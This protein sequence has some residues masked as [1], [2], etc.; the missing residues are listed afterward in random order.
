MS[1]S[2]KT[3]VNA[4]REEKMKQG[5]KDRFI[6]RQTQIKDRAGL[7]QTRAGTKQRQEV[8]DLVEAALWQFYNKEFN[9]TGGRRPNWYALTTTT[10]QREDE[11]GN[12][13]TSPWPAMPV[14]TMANIAVSVMQDAVKRD[15]T[16]MTTVIHLGRQYH[17]EMFQ[18]L[19]NATSKGREHMKE[20][21]KWVKQK[22]MCPQ[23]RIRRAV[24]HAKKLGYDFEDWPDEDYWAVGSLL[25][26]GALY[27]KKFE[28]EMVNDYDD[29]E[30]H[31]TRKVSLT[32]EAIAE[33][34]IGESKLQWSSP[35]FG[36]MASPPLK[37]DNLDNTRSPYNMPM[38]SRQTPLVKN[39]P[40]DQ[41]EAME[42]AL[43]SGQ[44]NGALEALN[45][46]QEVPYEINTYVLDA[47]KFATKT[48]G[49]AEDIASF[50]DLQRTKLKKHDDAD[51]A[52][53][54]PKQVA[55][56]WK[57]RNEIQLDNRT[58]VA[59][60]LNIT[61]HLE[62]A[63]ELA[64]LGVFWLPHQFDSRSR[65]Y[66]TPHFGHH[67]QDYLRSLFLFHN[68]TKVKG[69]E[70]FLKLQMA[71]SYGYDS[72]TK[73]PDTGE[74]GCNIDK[75]SL[76]GRLQWVDDNE[77]AILR[78]GEKFDLTLETFQFWSS[79]DDSLQF[80]AACREYYLFKQDPDNYESGLPIG[81]DATN[82]G[83]QHYA[84]ATRDIG[85]ASWV[86]L[87]PSGTSEKPKDIYAEA[88]RIT[89][90]KLEEDKQ[91]YTNQ[92]SELND[93]DAIENKK[94][95]ITACEELLASV[96]KSW[97]L[98]RKV[99]KRPCM[100]WAYSSRRYGM[101]KQLKKDWMNDITKDANNGK[102]PDGHPFSEKGWVACD[103]LAKNIEESISTVA[104]P[105]AEGMAFF[106]QC[107]RVM[108][109]HG[110]H[111]TF[112]TPMGFPMHQRYCEPEYATVETKD[113]FKKQVRKKRVRL[114]LMDIE[115]NMPEKDGRGNTVVYTDKVDARKSANAIAPN[116]I[117]AMDATHL[118]MTVLLCKQNGVTDFMAVHDSFSTSIGNVGTL[119]EAIRAAFI[120]LYKDYDLFEDILIQ[121][122]E[123]LYDHLL[124]QW[125][126]E[127]IDDGKEV[128][129]DLGEVLVHYL[130][131]DAG[132]PD[133]QN[134]GGLDL[135]GV[136][137]SEYCFS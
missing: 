87:L 98:K 101:K 90:E 25:Y 24:N 40:T 33:L 102:F 47:I 129:N 120:G 26:S 3:V 103:Q 88:L 39:S 112:T 115:T 7:S 23:D 10:I 93:P 52:G 30:M 19:V 68:K 49:V 36:P 105:A 99:A 14:E 59:N 123:R 46:L 131:H 89:I 96:G 9:R 5:G 51:I 20:I 11:D 137:E 29:R 50:P 100:T 6:K 107:A 58:V 53:L 126:Q 60:R 121:C 104:Q 67:T 41:Q 109:K 124:P 32:P 2:N 61:A 13:I 63:D 73:D 42:L 75:L 16:L 76:D 128:P 70:H 94:R 91:T 43:Q 62:E 57:S 97:G 132:F 114:W 85:L 64:E 113:G 92:L 48:K 106:Q 130:R 12:L 77:V 83:A 44:M 118:M 28:K 84:A 127:H 80:L 86:N 34:E 15:W 8:L 69:N 55:D 108:A 95:Y 4:V 122:R 27:S 18:V 78:A 119:T 110:L 81:L 56:Y 54:D 74:L 31:S 35:K 79:A 65:V 82:S 22:T 135:D 66:H 72:K 37:W 1:E 38:L 21:D 71:N 117:H 133:L 111:M 134:P 17:I 116:I 45:T 125:E 136:M